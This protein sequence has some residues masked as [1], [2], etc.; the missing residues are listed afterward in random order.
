[1]DIGLPSSVVARPVAAICSPDTQR[2]YSVS[3]RFSTQS[4]MSTASI[5]ASTVAV[6][7]VSL[8]TAVSNICSFEA[9]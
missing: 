7:A 8:I 9:I 5:G 6:S 3:G 4:A 2:R 1:M